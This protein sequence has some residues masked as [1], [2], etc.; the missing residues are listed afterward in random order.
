MSKMIFVNLPVRDLAKSMA[1]YEALGFTKE[2]RFTDETAAAMVW[3]DSNFVMLLTH[4]KWQSFTDRP[5]PPTSASEVSLA[6]AMEDRAA[7]DAMIAAAAAHGGTADINP[8][9]DHGFMYGRDLLDPDGHVW[10]PF[11]MDPAVANGEAAVEGAGA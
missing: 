3:S 11:W 2:P 5:I 1:F 7:V 9:Q 6:L 10:G 8:V 4:E